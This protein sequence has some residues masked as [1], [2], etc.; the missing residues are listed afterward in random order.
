MVTRHLGSVAR[1]VAAALFIS[2]V[3]PV[4]AQVP[5][6]HA[7]D[8][9]G[10]PREPIRN[11]GATDP[12]HEMEVTVWLKLNDQAHF[13]TLLEELYDPKSPRYRQWLSEEDL[14]TFKPTAEQVA[15]V[16]RELEAYGLATSV[17]PKG[18]FVRAHGTAT[19]VQ[20][21]FHTSL[22][23]FEK[24][25]RT[26]N[27]NVAPAA[28]HGPAGSLVFEAVGL[29]EEAVM[30]PQ[31]VERMDPATGQPWRIPLSQ[32]SLAP[33]SLPPLFTTQCFQPPGTFLVGVAGL[34]PYASYTGNFYQST[35]SGP[36]S[37]FCAYTPAQLQDH[38]GLTAAYARGLQGEGQTIVI[39]DGYGS[40]SILQDAN[41]FAQLTGLP[42]LTSTN[43]QIVYPDGQPRGY[44]ESWAIETSLDVE[45][46]HA[47][48]PSAKIVL[49]VGNGGSDQEL[50]FVLQYAINN[51]L[52]E[53]ISNSWGGP[54]FSA[55]PI[56][57]RTYNQL[58]AL[59]AAKGISV[60][61][62]S[63]DSGDWGLGSPVG[64][65]SFPAS[66]PYVT[67]VGGT[68]L[69]V[70][71]GGGGS[72]DVGWGN[73]LGTLVQNAATTGSFIGGG[74]G[75]ESLLNSK[76]S[77]QKALPG[78]GRQTP[79]I[80][81][82]ADPLTSVPIVVTSFNSFSG[83]SRQVLGLVGGTSLACPVFTAIWALADQQAGHGLGQAA[84]AIAR[85]PPAALRDIVP[86]GSANDVTEVLVD[87]S[88]A[89]SYS[90][91]QLAG[92]IFDT[93]T[94]FSAI[95][96]SPSSAFNGGGPV[97]IRPPSVLTF[98]TDSSLTTAPGWDNV[99]GFG[100]PNGWEFIAAAAGK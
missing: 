78:G 70:P 80:S 34:V 23:R 39:V 51:H 7:A 10:S 15:T 44:N 43:F 29:D 79:D 98:G 47:M 2:H 49:V 13:D 3:G 20:S 90:A 100:S 64:A 42:A 46:A 11:L 38:Y 66:S 91:A 56:A 63:G 65:A 85:M 88:G 24:A 30:R 36:S 41:S 61:F 12:T 83:Q 62:A 89:H 99:T 37:Q 14:A 74:G 54:E 97:L 95:F 18:F 4:P 81:A 28:L 21:A 45:W 17:D 50:Q 55:G 94:F 52:G 87:S 57:I 8:R 35:P 6:R 72:A 58:F 19:A 76:P 73:N 25:G 84:P 67:A 48:A 75:G 40:P 92:P 77:W 96:I 69:G 9:A 1:F 60:H 27:A 68:S 5:E 31:L 93:T 33:Q 22:Y 71:T 82:I 59:A 16:R 32:V 53:V 26:F 86:I